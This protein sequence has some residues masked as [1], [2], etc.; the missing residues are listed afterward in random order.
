MLVFIL[1]KYLWSIAYNIE[2]N[3]F[4]IIFLTVYLYFR[5]TSPNNA[6]K[7]SAR[8]GG[9]ENGKTT[10]ATLGVKKEIIAEHENGV[11]ASDLVS[12]NGMPKSTIS[13][14]LKNREMIKAANVAKG[15]KVISKQRP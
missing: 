9:K 1:L 14:I 5:Y 6:P 13:T 11:C 2:H 10:R 12:R 8:D 3:N 7:K 4:Y 15:S